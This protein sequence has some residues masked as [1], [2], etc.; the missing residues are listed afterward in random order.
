MAAGELPSYRMRSPLLPTLLLSGAMACGP[1]TES[2][3][4]INTRMVTLPDGKQ[5]RAEVKIK[6]D[7]MARGMMFRSSLPPGR[8]ML[9][10]HSQPGPYTY[11]MPDVQIPLDIVFMDPNRRIVEI[12]AG[13]PPCTTKREDCPH[14]GGHHVEQ[15]V[16]ELG[17]GE[18][19]RLG[20]KVGQELWF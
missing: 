13:A 8:G 1:A 2:L 12:A 19:Q 5:I 18:A 16:L 4:E 10:I 20:L 9:F 15:Y 17:A 6:P 14:Y 7:E 11:W 3:D